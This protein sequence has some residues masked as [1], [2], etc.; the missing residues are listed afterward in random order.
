M[1]PIPNLPQ[2]TLPAEIAAMVI[3]LNPQSPE[4]FAEVS[5]SAVGAGIEQLDVVTG[6]ANLSP[7]FIKAQITPRGR[8]HL[9]LVHVGFVDDGIAAAMFPAFARE[10]YG[11][12]GRYIETRFEI[13]FE[14]EGFLRGAHIRVPRYAV[15]VDGYVAQWACLRYKD[16]VPLH[17]RGVLRVDMFGMRGN[18][19][20]RLA[21]AQCLYLN[22]HAV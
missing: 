11:V 10:P 22:T 3:N 15:E 18:E 13:D 9:S 6:Q 21:A 12:K 16:N 7:D 4:P 8:P 5:T 20:V 2:Q 19:L 1:E 17:R 14:R